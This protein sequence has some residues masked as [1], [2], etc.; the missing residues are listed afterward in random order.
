MH[1]DAVIFDFF[2]TLT[3]PWVESAHLS[4]VSRVASAMDVPP[5][6]LASVLASSFDERS[7][8]RWGSFEDTMKRLAAEAGVHLTPAEL[9]AVCQ[10][11]LE[12]NAKW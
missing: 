8:G 10:A 9:A 2:G 12:T 4:A 6:R 7:Q 5:R 1:Y 11:R 3:L